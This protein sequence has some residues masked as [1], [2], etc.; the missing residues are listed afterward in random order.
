MLSY[1]NLFLI[2]FYLL[3]TVTITLAQDNPLRPVNCRFVLPARV[4]IECMSLTVPE[5]RMNP[6]S[7]TITLSLVILRNPSGNPEPDPIIFLQG[8]PGGATLDTLHLT[9]EDRFE[10]L[11][12][13][14]R[15]II[16]FDQRGVGNSR[17]AL[18]CPAYRNAEVDLLD[19]NF[20]GQSLPRPQ[21]EMLLNQALVDCGELLSNRHDLSGYNS[22]QNAADIE[23]IRQALGYEEVNLW[24]ISYGSRLGLTAMRDYPN[25][26]RRVVL[27]GVYPLEVNVHTELPAN[28]ERSLQLLFDD[29]E[30]DRACNR[31]YPDLETVL[32]DT[33]HRLN[34]N[35]V[36]FNAPNPYTNETFYGVFYNG[37]LM[38]HTI[39]RL[40]YASEILPRL[41]ELIYDVSEGRLGIWMILVGWLAGQR[42]TFAI[43]M[44][45]AV[46]CQEEYYFTEPGSVRSEWANYPQ[47]E[48]YSE[49]IEFSVEMARI[50][51]AFNSGESPITE[52]QAISSDIPTLLIAGEYDPVTPPQW[53][54]QVD[55]YLTNSQYLEFEAHGHGA[56][57]FRGCA[58]SI[59]IDFFQLEDT[60]MLDTT[61]MESIHMRFSGTRRGDFNDSDSASAIESDG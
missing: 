1:R 42:D 30:S 33:V 32:Y 6:E 2:S 59:M 14:N 13:T 40:L 58:Q 60:T 16:L 8:G 47:F 20:N 17:P 61:C 45:Y 54:L 5:N 4:E 56:S 37:D 35:P 53:A 3:L 51:T 27:D 39:F 19:Y 24:G 55:E 12:A 9:Y 49:R 36:R 43:G 25:S 41:P 46:Q 29:C 38:L 34:E 18:N 10:P 21:I 44:N 28:F 7:D 52:N 57:A 31:S 48:T 26:F 23:A 11:F 15:D 22:V 50:C